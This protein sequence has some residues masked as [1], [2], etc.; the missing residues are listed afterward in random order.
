VVQATDA[1]RQAGGD[2]VELNVHGRLDP[3]ADQ[4]YFAGMA[5]PRYRD[6]LVTWVEQLAQVDIPL[7]LKF[8]TDYDVDFDQVLDD[9]GH[10]P[11][12]GHHFNVRLPD[13]EQPNLV[14]VGRIRPLVQGVLLCSGY[15]WDAE[16]VEALFGLGVD[17]VGVA[18]PVIRDRDFIA[19]M[20]AAIG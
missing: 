5:L 10:I 12:F 4:G 15:A 1:F 14:F 3:F 8:R 17:A 18:Q 19:K 6:R 20:A 13:A 16:T 9:L 2:F 11:L 7:L